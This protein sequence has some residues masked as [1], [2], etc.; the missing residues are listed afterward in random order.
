MFAVTFTDC[1]KQKKELYFLNDCA[2]LTDE[3]F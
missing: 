2:I 3:T 1:A